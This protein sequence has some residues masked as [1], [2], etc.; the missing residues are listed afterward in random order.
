[1]ELGI[2]GLG[3]MGGNMATRLLRDGHRVVGFNRTSDPLRTLAGH[4]GEPADSIE[5]LVKA[6]RPPRAVWLMVPAGAVTEEVLAHVAALLDG[7][8]V[9][10]DG[11]NS[12]WTDSMRRAEALAAR[13]LHFVD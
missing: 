8:D 2:V 9:V 13:G 4:G 12:R 1:M 11:G 7:G 3:R 6:L 10:I 5:A